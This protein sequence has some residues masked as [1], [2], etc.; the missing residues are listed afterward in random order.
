MDDLEPLIRQK[1]L[2]L[3]R[4]L[5]SGAL[6]FEADEQMIYRLF[7]NL[8]VNAMKFTPTGGISVSS[9]K[10]DGKI[11]VLVSDT[12]VGIE[13]D[14]LKRVFDRFFQKTPATE[15]MGVGLALVREIAVLHGGEI[16]AESTGAGKG[17]TFIVEFPA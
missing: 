9:L 15:G 1:Q 6:P 11:R 10:M 3:E 7:S 16:W 12:G 17:A 8:I 13:K 4:K 2:S 5:T 14:D